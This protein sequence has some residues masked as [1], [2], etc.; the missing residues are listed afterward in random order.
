MSPL[1]TDLPSEQSAAERL[2]DLDRRRA[3]MRRSFFARR[4]KRIDNVIAQL[5][6][7]RGYAQIRA[8]GEREAAWQ[9][10]LAQQGAEQWAEQ[11]RF[12]GLKRG[13]F[14]VQ[15]ANSMLMQEL[16]FRK[17]ALLASLQDSLQEDTVK[18]LRF[19]IGDHY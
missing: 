13:V 12:A 8:A 2:A 16:T 7:R 4:P 5:V 11:T 18:Q 3:A 14:A 17:E 1:P 19:T 9:T 6:Q 10:A 15:V